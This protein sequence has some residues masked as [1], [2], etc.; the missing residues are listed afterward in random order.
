MVTLFGLALILGSGSSGSGG[1]S[2]GR[3]VY[4]TKQNKTK[5]TV[6]VFELQKIIEL[7]LIFKSF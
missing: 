4:E 5:Q 6:E 3:F 7:L 2:N 1:R